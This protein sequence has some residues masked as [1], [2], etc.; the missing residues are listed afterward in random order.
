MQLIDTGANLAHESFTDDLDAVLMRAQAAGVA[1]LMVTGSDRHSSRAALDLARRYPGRCFA[2]AGLHP[3]QATAWDEPMAELMRSHANMPEC[4]ALGEMGLDFFRDIA[5]R[6]VQE[7]VFARQLTI[8]CETNMPVFLHQRDAHERFLP[9]LGEYLPHLPAAVVH[10]FTGC[11]KELDAYLAQDLYIGITG[12]VCDERR[13]RHLSEIVD[14]IPDHRLLIETDAP[15]LMP[16]TI[17]PRPKTRRNE[18]ANLSHIV[19]TLA[20]ARCQSPQAIAE[21]TTAN[22]RRFFDLPM[23]QPTE[24]YV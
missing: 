12:W 10:C 18:P 17:R 19:D 15:Y 7:R 16:R 3:H 22:A 2:T 20:Q 6:D 21:L 8:A 24:N 5:P 1:Q 14:R 9:I 4:R 13:G 23:P 11:D